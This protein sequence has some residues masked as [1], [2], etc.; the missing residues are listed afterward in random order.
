MALNEAMFSEKMD[1]LAGS[2]ESIQNT[3]AWCSLWRR[4]A[5]ALVGWW[6]TYFSKADMAK[7]LSMI[8]LANEVVQTRCDRGGNCLELA[9]S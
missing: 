7:R 2:Q 6:E 4:D 8:Y 5:R 3:S 1:K 9:L